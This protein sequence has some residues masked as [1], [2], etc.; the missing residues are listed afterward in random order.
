MEGQT[1]QWPKEKG[2]KDTQRSTKRTH[3]TKDRV[4]RTALKTG[5]VFRCSERISTSCF[6]S[7]TR[8]IP[9]LGG[10]NIA[11]IFAIILINLPPN[12]N[13]RTITVTLTV[14]DNDIILEFK[15][16]AILLHYLRKFKKKYHYFYIIYRNTSKQYHF[17]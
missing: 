5:G 2:Q 4:T 13:A 1:T 11:R 10:N 15:K 7:G 16:I 14:A 17:W 9:M 8:L 6:T 3:K 12:V